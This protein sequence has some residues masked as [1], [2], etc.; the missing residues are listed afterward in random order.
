VS[1]PDP[2]PIKRHKAD[3]DEWKILRKLKLGPCR[4]CK[5]RFAVELHHLVGRDLGGDDKPDNLVPLC[6][7]CHPKVEEREPDACLVLRATLSLCEYA[8]VM[9]KKGARFMDTY[10]P[11]RSAED[12]QTTRETDSSAA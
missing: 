7:L 11:R 5:G 12:V 2:R 6:W 4:V 1:A 3:V 9:D 10:Y 8:Y